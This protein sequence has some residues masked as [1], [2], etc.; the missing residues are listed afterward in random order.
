MKRMSRAYK[1]VVFM[2][3]F[4]IFLFLSQPKISLYRREKFCYFLLFCAT[5][6]ADF[7]TN[8]CK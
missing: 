7:D 5:K 3:L 2:R 8:N 4:G 6:K 1:N